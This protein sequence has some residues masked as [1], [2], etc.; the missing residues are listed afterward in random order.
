M[1]ASDPAEAEPLHMEAV[2]LARAAGDPWHLAIALAE[3]AN[4][5]IDRDA[6]LAEAAAILERLGAAPALER[7]AAPALR[8]TTQA[9]G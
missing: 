7:L 1:L 6:A 2:T 9:A 3:Q 4:A 5:G 8:D